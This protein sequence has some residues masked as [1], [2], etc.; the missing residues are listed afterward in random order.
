MVIDDQVRLVL[1]ADA[2][3][4][5]VARITAS[6]LALRLGLSFRR[7]DDLR[8]AIVEALVLLLRG[9]PADGS[10]SVVFTVMSRGLTVDLSGSA[11]AG[12]LSLDDEERFAELVASIVDAAE[13]RD[14]GHAVHLETWYDP[15]PA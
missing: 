7:I 2:A 1:P 11:G 12:P 14:G 10:I 3:Y 15:P 5:R 6:S 9:E 13:L 8:L 4:G